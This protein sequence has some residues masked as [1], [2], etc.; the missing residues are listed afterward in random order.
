MM[1]INLLLLSSILAARGAIAGETAAPAAQT[2]APA[3]PAAS[4]LQTDDQKTLYALGMAIGRNVAPLS[5]SA[6]E[7]KYVDM[8]LK[9]SALGKK[10]QV[11]MNV[12]GPKVQEFAQSRMSAGADKQK[13]KDKAFLAKAAK[14]PGAKTTESGLVFKD[15]KAGN[16]ASPTATD[17]VKVNYKGTFPDGKQFDSS[18]D[19][20]QPAE[21]PLNGVVPCW[22]EGIQKM[23]VG[24]KARLVCPSNIAYGDQGRPPQIPGGATLVFEVELLDILRK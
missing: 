5:L 15:I 13:A 8:G 23:K 7:L 3:A 18:Y 1:K 24:G 10:I 4:A 11:D 2:Q 9:D 12:Y 22:T 20:G 16:G 21:F 17:T 6:S 19:R 14:E